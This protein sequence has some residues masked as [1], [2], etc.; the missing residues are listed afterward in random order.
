MKQAVAILLFLLTVSFTS[1]QTPQVDKEEAR[2]AFELINRIRMSPKDFSRQLKVNINSVKPRAALIW[3]DTL[4]KV[5]EEKA[6]DMATK[7]YF[8][9]VDKSG[10]GIN[11]YINKAGYRLNPEWVKRKRDNN[12]ESLDAGAE[13]GEKAVV[14]LVVDLNTA[15]HA[16]R[17]H[18]LGIDPWNAS[19][20]DI[21]IG[22]VNGGER[23]QFKVYM[24]V[25]IAKHDW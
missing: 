17:N 1:F 16:H 24:C 25:I 11:Y 10:Y 6:M 19:L 22:F 4:A 21:G 8:A 5:A 23:S 13:T 12:F 15:G 9:H 7:N 3:N 14:D 18:L 20:T 2:S